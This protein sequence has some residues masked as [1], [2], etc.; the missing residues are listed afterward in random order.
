[1]PRIVALAA[2]LALPF[3]GSAQTAPTLFADRTFGAGVG[4]V[5]DLAFSGDGRLI[6][7][8]GNN[9]RLAVWDAQTASLVREV[10][11]GSEP[12][13]RVAFGSGAVAAGTARGGVSVVNLVTGQAREVARHGR[14]EITALA[15]AGDG[16]MGASG[17]AEGEL[18]VWSVERGQPERLREDTRRDP[19]VFLAFVTPTTLVSITRQLAVTTWD[20]ARRRSTRRAT[21]QVESLGRSAEFQAAHAEATGAQIG[22]SSQYL[23]RQRGGVL[24]AS[25]IARPEDLRR[26]NVIVPYATDSGIA[27]D[28]IILGEFFA[29][30]LALSPGGCFALFTSSNREQGRLHL[31]SLVRQG[32]DLTRQELPARA[33]A[34]AV[35]PT[36]R[37]LAVG[38]PNGEVATWRVSGAT[39]GDCQLYRN[40]QS[41][42]QRSGPRIA[43]GTQATPLFA[44]NAGFRVAVM[45]FEAGNLDASVGDGVAE[46]V[47]GELANS[48][49]VVVVERAAIE[50]IVKELQLQASGLTAADAARVGRG[51]N[52]RKV[53]LGGVRR[54]GDSTFVLT[55]RVVDVETQ[56][57]EGSREVSCESCSEAD[58][59]AAARALRQTIVP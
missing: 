55:A 1:M 25:G 7:V 20:V 19:V 18:L 11:L 50:A 49:S 43:V 29:E 15:L 47:G 35:D 57:V 6:A 39:P 22:L 59:P 58:L 10:P 3:V 28:P 46:M 36:G 26:T 31:W 2:V 13:A 27:A 42:I 41:P 30:R 48:A 16:S 17:D 21:L 33:D 45:R 40:A 12:N 4:R 5:A 32:Q 23:A 54:F 53:V 44:A 51:L 52:A 56:Q 24:G 9:G 8:V 34:I 38:F 37:S 14:N